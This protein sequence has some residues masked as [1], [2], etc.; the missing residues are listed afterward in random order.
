[1]IEETPEMTLPK[2]WPYEAD[3]VRWDCII[4]TRQGTR[5]LLSKMEILNDPEALKTITKSIAIFHEIE[6]N[7]LAVGPIA[8]RFA[9]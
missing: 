3:K 7:L 6:L 2:R 4:K 9:S 5:L 8:D 1:M